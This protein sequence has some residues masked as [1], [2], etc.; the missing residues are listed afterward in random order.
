MCHRKD[1]CRLVV[2]DLAHHG[3][4]GM[5]DQVLVHRMEHLECLPR[6]SYCQSEQQERRPRTKTD[7]TGACEVLELMYLISRHVLDIKPCVDLFWCGE[8]GRHPVVQ[9]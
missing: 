1:T 8:D 2:L 4:D 5:P 7:M 9:P 6:K 3:V